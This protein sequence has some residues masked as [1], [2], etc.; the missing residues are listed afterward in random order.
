MNAKHTAERDASRPQGRPRINEIDQS[1]Q[2]HADPGGSIGEI[3]RRW[4]RHH[5][6]AMMDC[7]T[8][9]TVARN[10]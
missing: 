3:T 10:E 1:E 6:V 8:A 5:A 4:S 9:H 7:A 2:R